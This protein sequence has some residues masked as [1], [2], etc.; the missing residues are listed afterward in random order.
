MATDL[1]D[2]RLKRSV[3]R[4]SAAQRAARISRDFLP[5]TA[6]AH[7]PTLRESETE[8]PFYS[9]LGA[10]ALVFS[11]LSGLMFMLAASFAT[12]QTHPWRLWWLAVLWT[13]VMVCIERLILQV[14]NGRIIPL[15]IAAVP[16]LAVSVLIALTVSEVAGLAMYK[17]EINSYLV[18]QRAKALATIG[19]EVDRIYGP[20]TLEAKN[21]IT[22]LKFNERKVED[23]IAREDLRSQQSQTSTG[24]C[25]IRCGYYK[26][27]ADDDRRLLATMRS[28]NQGRFAGRRAQV[29]RL[30]DEAQQLRTDRR[31]SVIEQDGLLARVNALSQIAK[32]EPAVHYMVLLLRLLLVALDL[33]AFAAKLVRVLTVKNSPYDKNLEGRR[34]EESL[35]G[36]ERLE[37]SRTREAQIHD[38]GRAARR[39]NRWRADAED[40]ERF[41]TDGKRYTGAAGGH[42]APIEGH[43]LGE[44]TSD[45][46]DWETRPIRVPDTVRRGGFIGLGLLLVTLLGSIVLSAD[47]LIV[48]GAALLAGVGLLAFTRGFRTAPGWALRAIFATL[49]TGIAMPF[50]ILLLN[51]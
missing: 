19:P 50:L 51:L 12:G 47:G 24:A 16:R 17:P 46:T 38:E 48:V 4:P 9:A 23:R 42:A 34:A 40:F 37:G 7:L 8:R 11:C 5:W 25:A 32:T 28:R 22:R 44:F 41:D 31:R 36:E 3:A 15:V 43:S 33:T 20:K 45:M 39:R 2:P 21:E 30:R 10:A 26:K 27:L 1:R 29:R 35:T 14:P 18:E 13:A 6:G 49:L